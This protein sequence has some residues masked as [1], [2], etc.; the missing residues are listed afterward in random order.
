VVSRRDAAQFYWPPFLAATQRGGVKSIMCSYNAVCL[1]CD[2]SIINGT[3]TPSCAD[4]ALQNEMVRGEWGWDGFF[5]SDCDAVKNIFDP[6]HFAPSGLDAAV[7]GLNGGT[8][9]D[10]GNTYSQYLAAA[11]AAGNLTEAALRLAAYRNMRVAFG[12]GLWDAPGSV[13]YD[14]IGPG[15]LDSADNRALSLEAAIQGLVLLQNNA[16]AGGKPLL[17]LSLPALRGKGIA[18]IGPLAN[19]TQTLLSNYEGGNTLVDSHSILAALSARAGAAGVPLRYA[20]GCVN[21]TGGTTV[22]CIDG[23]GFA[24]AVDAAAAADVA[25]VVVGLCSTCPLDGWR[26]EGEGHDR[27][28]LTLPG[29]QE[30][31]V[32]AV[33]AT[34]TPVVLV[35]V[36]GGPLAIEG[37]LAVTP[38]ILDAHYPGQLGG[39]AVAAVLLGDAS[40]SGRLTTTVYPAGFVQ[41]RA[42]TDMALAPHDGRPGVTHLYVPRQDVV[43]PFGWGLSYTNFKF[44]WLSAASGVGVLR[45]GAVPPQYSVN[46]TNVGSVTSDVSVLGMYSTGIPGEPLEELFDFERVAALAPGQTVTV[47]L[48]LPA[49]VVSKKRGGWGGRVS[50]LSPPSPLDFEKHTPL[51]I[52]PQAAA[53]DAKGVKSLVAGEFDVRIGEPD[54]WIWGKVHV[55]FGGVLTVKEA[56]KGPRDKNLL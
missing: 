50:G 44:T 2:P 54:N 22:W 30:A 38:S 10:C 55:E 53:V 36:H 21:S 6:H 35:L 43:F 7:M 11:V 47:T 12:L 20:P 34:G 48:S 16:T 27:H 19:A 29:Q 14:S 40:P 32:K 37:L 45:L 17:P 52:H 49:G 51:S 5:V 31:L 42:L 26:L 13:S 24:P 4:S 8:D 3:G 23:G 56:T 41:Q 1:D 18:L 15:R 28:E 33:A 39:D 46:V 25:V 9:I